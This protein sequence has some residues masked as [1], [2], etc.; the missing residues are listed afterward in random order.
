MADWEV[1]LFDTFKRWEVLA[2]ACCV[3]FSCCFMQ[4]FNAELAISESKGQRNVSEDHVDIWKLV[5]LLDCCLPIA[6]CAINRML[7][8]KKFGIQD[9]WG[10]DVIFWVFC[11]CFAASQEVVETVKRMNK[12]ES[13]FSFCM[14]CRKEDY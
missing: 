13:M 7:L 6:G 5:V 10:F 9:H 11:P 3:P 1:K 14:F 12:P 4:V 2:F 8:R